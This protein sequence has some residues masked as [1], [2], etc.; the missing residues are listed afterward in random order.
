MVRYSM[1]DYELDRIEKSNKTDKKYMAILKNKKSNKN[2]TIHFGGDP[3]K[4]QHY[5]DKLGYYSHL[6]HG[7]PLRLKNYYARHGDEEKGYYSALYFSN[8][9][10]W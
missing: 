3:N 1:K 10:L 4:Y 5:Y 7:D 9:Y 6:N 2:I 8:Y